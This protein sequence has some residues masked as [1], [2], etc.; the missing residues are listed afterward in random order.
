MAYTI[1]HA[2]YAIG[3]PPVY[4]PMLDSGQ[5]RG[6]VERAL[7]RLGLLKERE[8]CPRLPRYGAAIIVAAPGQET[9]WAIRNQ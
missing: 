3:Q 7:Q 9:L 4:G 2:T 8:K 6:Q 5:T 1:H